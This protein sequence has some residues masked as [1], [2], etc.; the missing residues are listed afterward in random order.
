MANKFV[1]R[2]LKRNKTLTFISSFNHFKYST[3]IDGGLPCP[4]SELGHSK[5]NELDQNFA[6]LTVVPTT[7]QSPSHKSGEDWGGGGCG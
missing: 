7:F 5:P 1:I 2:Y 3:H 6:V 4:S